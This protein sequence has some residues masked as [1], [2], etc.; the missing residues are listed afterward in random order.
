M[1]SCIIHPPNKRSSAGSPET[2]HFP[3]HTC[4][5]NL[6]VFHIIWIAKSRSYNGVKGCSRKSCDAVKNSRSVWLPQ[7]RDF[8]SRIS[9]DDFGFYLDWQTYGEQEPNLAE[10]CRTISHHAVEVTVLDVVAG[11]SEMGRDLT[12]LICE[13]CRP[14]KQEF[15][16]SWCFLI[17]PLL[18]HISALRFEFFMTLTFS[19]TDPF[20]SR[21][22]I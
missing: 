20:N 2:K 15:L 9:F 18:R 22:R 14:Q 5:T 6:L 11:E 17:P 8:P 10:Y 19:I 3:V 7:T 21:R 16:G 4:T 1:H 12:S 13:T